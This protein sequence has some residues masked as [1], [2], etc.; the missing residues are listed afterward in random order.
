MSTQYQLSLQVLSLSIPPISYLI[1]LFSSSPVTSPPA[2]S[3]LFPF[4]HSVETPQN[5][6]L[7]SKKNGACTGLSKSSAYTEW[8]CGLVF[9]WDFL[10]VGWN[11]LWLFDLHWGPFIPTA[12]PCLDVNEGLCLFL[13]HLV[14]LCSVGIPWRLVLYWRAKRRSRFVWEERYQQWREG[15]L[16]S[17]C[18]V[19]KSMS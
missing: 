7:R 10:T 1:L 18:T 3:I 13:S 12:L 14:R 17:R 2:K 5:V 9:L 11:C 6:P 16:W 8:L 4:S 15:E 19:C